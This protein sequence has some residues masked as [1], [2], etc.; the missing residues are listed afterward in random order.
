MYVTAR[1]VAVLGLIIQFVTS[2]K[3]THF[4]R[5]KGRASTKSATAR[6][7]HATFCLAAIV[8]SLRSKEIK[9]RTNKGGLEGVAK[10]SNDIKKREHE[11]NDDARTFHSHL[12]LNETGGEFRNF[13]RV[14]TKRKKKKV[15]RESR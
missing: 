11:F 8:S 7:T 13:V 5:T 10:F 12:L 15:A 4:Q 3:V 14:R 1:A 2:S 6:D 9:Q